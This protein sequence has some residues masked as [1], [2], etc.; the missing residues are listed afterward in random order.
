MA[1][2]YSHHIYVSILTILSLTILIDVMLWKHLKVEVEYLY[3]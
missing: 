1:L 2:N 3:H